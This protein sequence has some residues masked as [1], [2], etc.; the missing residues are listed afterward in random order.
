L[1]EYLTRVDNMYQELEGRLDDEIAAR[2]EEAQQK[3]LDPAQRGATWTYLTTDRP[4][5][6]FTER[7][8]RGLT[9]KFQK[10]QLWG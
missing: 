9:R 5:G 4:F 3:G 1:H 2:L 10:R 7:V 8:L 6:D